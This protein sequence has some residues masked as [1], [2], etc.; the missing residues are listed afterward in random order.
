MFKTIFF[1]GTTKLGGTAPDFRPWP[2]ARIAA[3]HVSRRQQ[4]QRC[5]MVAEHQ[6]IPLRSNSSTLQTEHKYG[7][8]SCQ[9]AKPAIRLTQPRGCRI[10][11]RAKFSSLVLCFV[12][13]LLK[14][15]QQ[16]LPR[17]FVITSQKT[18]HN[19]NKKHKV[20]SSKKRSE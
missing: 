20:R 7:E 16:T 17:Q 12:E 1:L 19:I 15:L 3:V 2:Q 4:H 14:N 5:A 10:E 18:R 8:K 9:H 13:D 11:T 6:D